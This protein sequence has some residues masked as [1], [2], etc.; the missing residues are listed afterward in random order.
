MPYPDIS[1]REKEIF[2]KSLNESTDSFKFEDGMRFSEI[3]KRYYPRTEDM[4]GSTIE[5]RE[6]QIEKWINSETTISASNEDKELVAKIL[7]HR[8]LKRKIDEWVQDQPEIIEYHK[9]A[10]IISDQL[11]EEFKKNCFVGLGLDKPGT[12]I[13][14]V[15]HDVT[16]QYLIGNINENAGVC[17]DC[18]DF[19]NDAV[20]KRYMVLLEEGELDVYPRANK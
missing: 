10:K 7:A 19:Q 8:R 15:E 1:E 14:I 3:E 20:V 4:Y 17:D 9:Q 16:M 11:N 13:E 2:G 6:N 5:S 12:L 18:M